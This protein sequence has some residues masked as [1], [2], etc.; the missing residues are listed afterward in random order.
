MDRQVAIVTDFTR[1]ETPDILEVHRNDALYA[2]AGYAGMA[3]SADA[4]SQKPDFSQSMDGVSASY[5][6]HSL[7]PAITVQFDVPERPHRAASLARPGRFRSR[8]MCAM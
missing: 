7:V 3:G 1:A 2:R 4:V 6:P 8:A 5:Q